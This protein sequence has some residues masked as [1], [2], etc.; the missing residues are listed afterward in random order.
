[1]WGWREVG[2][3]EV[4]RGEKMFFSGIDPESYITEC[5]LVYEDYGP[6]GSGSEAGSICRIWGSFKIRMLGLSKSCGRFRAFGFGVD[7]LGF[8]VWGVG[9]RA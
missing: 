8:G 1:M 6:A 4:P 5:T 3:G 9:F 2:S 7:S